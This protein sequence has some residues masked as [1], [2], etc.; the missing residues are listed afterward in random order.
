MD[1][2]LA[3]IGIAGSLL[4]GGLVVDSAIVTKEEQ[5]ATLPT[6]LK[7]EAP[8]EKIVVSE[9]K[10]I[11][12][13]PTFDKTLRKCL[14]YATSTYQEYVYVSEEVETSKNIRFEEGKDY[15]SSEFLPKRA[16]G[17]TPIAFYAENLWKKENGI[18]KKL[19]KATTTP[20]AFLLQTRGNILKRIVGKIIPNVLAVS[21]YTASGSFTPNGSGTIEILVVAGGGGGSAAGGGAGGLV[22]DPTHSVT[23]QSYPVTVGT[24]GSGKSPGVA[25]GDNGV[26]SSFDT[27]TANGGGGAAH[28]N[29]LETGSTGGSGG[30]SGYTGDHTTINGGTAN[31]GNS[32]GGTGYGNNGGAMTWYADFP[33]PAGGG[34]GTGGVGQPNSDRKTAGAGGTGRAY[35]ISGGSVNYGGGGG[36]SCYSATTDPPNGCIAGTASYGGGP[37]QI[38]A[39]GSSGTDGTGG[40]GGGTSQNDGTHVGGTGGTGIVIIVDNTTAAGGAVQINQPAVKFE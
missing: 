30:G 38:S 29:P 18:V 17:K 37:G 2:T 21:S 12:S 36:G 26:N 35:S 31:Q 20:E 11:V 9:V 16:D 5:I 14:S 39:D 4:L 23:V 24:G 13:C 40:G 27:I 33:F 8:T 6:E 32:G 3:T 10:E 1:K 22:Y 7:L 25:K 28:N 34:G 15:S 19:K